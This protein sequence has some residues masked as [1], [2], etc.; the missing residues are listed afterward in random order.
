MVFTGLS[1]GPAHVAKMEVDLEDGRKTHWILVEDYGG[2]GE[3]SFVRIQESCSVGAD[4]HTLSRYH[5]GI[6]DHSAHRAPAKLTCTLCMLGSVRFM[7]VSAD[8]NVT[9]D[10]EHIYIMCGW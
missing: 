9:H 3:A 8:L 10:D 2:G 4:V 7:M 5:G 6:Y 1:E